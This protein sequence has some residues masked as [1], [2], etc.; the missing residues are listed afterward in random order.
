VRDG[1]IEALRP[2]DD[3][4]RL[5]I[6][7]MAQFQTLM[8]RWQKVLVARTMQ[9][10]AAAVLPAGPGRARTAISRPA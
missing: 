8:S 3:Q 9:S 10:A 4:E 5:L 7:Q 6:D 1:L 2:R